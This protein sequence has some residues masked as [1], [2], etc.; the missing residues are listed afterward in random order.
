MRLTRLITADDLGQWWV[1]DPL[2]A[3]MHGHPVKAECICEGP[4]SQ[5]MGFQEECPVHGLDIPT[6]P[7]RMRFHHYLAGLEC[8]HCVGTWVGY[9]VLGSYLLA[10]RSKRGLAAW[11]FIAAGLSINTVTVVAGKAVGYWE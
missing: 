3:W 1:K 2:D 6:L 9:G 11:R 5:N 10:R 7:D 4:P 8:P